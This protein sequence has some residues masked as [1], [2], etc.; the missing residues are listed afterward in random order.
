MKIIIENNLILELIR[1]SHANELF[2][3]TD[4]NRRYLRKWLPWVDSTRT[5][6]DTENFVKH[7]QRQKRTK[8]GI[9]F[10]IKYNGKISGMVGLVYID[11]FNRRTEIGYWLGKEYTGLGIM[12]KSCWAL[13]EYCYKELN[14]NKIII[15]CSLKN[16]ASI[17]IP[18]RL[19]FEKEAL[20]R[21]DTV[22]NKKFEDS[23]MF[24]I[25]RKEW[26]AKN[27]KEKI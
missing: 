16:K 1:R 24:T 17:G 10:V 26:N 13:T 9:Q 18:K 22:L 12:T 6:A 4:K 3:L 20:L 7:S 8:T 15:R 5:V 27:K 23:Y 25:L 19:R 11:R 2:A 14:M 21:E